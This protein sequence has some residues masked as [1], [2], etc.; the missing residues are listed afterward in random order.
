M[1]IDSGSGKSSRILE[2]NIL[3]FVRVLLESRGYI[4]LTARDGEEAFEFLKNQKKKPD[5]LVTDMFMPNM[6]GMELVEKIRK[7]KE[8]KSMKI[9]F[10]TVSTKVDYMDNLK[11]MKIAD[12]IYKPFKTEDLIK[13]IKKIIG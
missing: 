11:K 13:R 3:G 7:D 6:N 10:L 5:L 8:L 4:V 1:M 9:M 12:Y 2:E